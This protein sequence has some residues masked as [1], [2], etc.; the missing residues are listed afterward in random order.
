MNIPAKQ[1]DP[2]WRVK[3]MKDAPSS[4]KLATRLD[5]LRQHQKVTAPSNLGPDRDVA[6]LST[7]LWEWMWCIKAQPCETC[8]GA[9]QKV[10]GRTEASPFLMQR[11]Q[12][13]DGLNS[14]TGHV[15]RCH[16]YALRVPG[17]PQARPKQI[18]DL[19]ETM[20]VKES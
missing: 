17:I 14:H 10:Q 5:C 11:L 16:V 7:S 9:L 20:C 15:L 8:V 2:H 13:D 6:N 12:N 1:P 19:K 18:H 4:N 3:A